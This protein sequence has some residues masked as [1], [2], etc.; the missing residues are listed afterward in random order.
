MAG[1][2]SPI[3]TVAI[4]LSFVL[5]CFSGTVQAQIIYVD[6][7]APGVNKGSSWTDAYNH[8]QDALTAV[9]IGD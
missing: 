6:A 8:L 9:V 4:L 1:K 3:T 2:S 7:D 5:L